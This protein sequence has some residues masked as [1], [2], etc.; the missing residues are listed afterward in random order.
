MKRHPLA[1]HAGEYPSLAAY[2]AALRIERRS[3]HLG[4]VTEARQRARIASRTAAHSLSS[5][6]VANAT[7]VETGR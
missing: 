2:E 6:G 1:K 3:G 5:R 7:G 4:G